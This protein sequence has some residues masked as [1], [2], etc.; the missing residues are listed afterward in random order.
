MNDIIAGGISGIAQTTVGYPLDTIKVLAQN[1]MTLKNLNIRQLYRG[2]VYPMQS[3]VLSNSIVFSLNNRL[4]EKGYPS[5]I[6]GFVSGLCVSPLVY[7]YDKAKISR[8]V[9]NNINM[10]MYTNMRGF[11]MTLVRDSIAYGIYFMSYD[12]CRE[13][14]ISIPI[15][16]AIAGITNWTVTYPF[17]VIRNRQLALKINIFDAFKLGKLYRGLEYC[18]L[19]AVIVNS[20]AFSVYENVYNYL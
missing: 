20:I 5:F 11:S 10:E 2:V 14:H 17:D 1:N 18:L 3:S 4:K 19:R 8:Q 12:K 16:G 15:S 9:G 7:L 6:N 13:H